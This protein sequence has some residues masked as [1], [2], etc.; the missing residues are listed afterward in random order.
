M[1][2]EIEKTGDLSFSGLEDCSWLQIWNNDFVATMIS[3]ELFVANQTMITVFDFIR[4]FFLCSNVYGVAIY[5]LMFDEQW[6]RQ[7]E[8]ENYNVIALDIC[9]RFSIEILRGM[10]R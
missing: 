5:Y 10:L 9:L 2:V 3:I 4:S 8:K 7:L 1:N 6:E